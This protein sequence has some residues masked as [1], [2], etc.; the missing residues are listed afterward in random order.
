MLK[1]ISSLGTILSKN[2]QKSFN[3]GAKLCTTCGYAIPNM[4]V[5]ADGTQ[6]PCI[7]G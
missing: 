5:C 7:P 1:K 3:G 2:E 4:I 6:I